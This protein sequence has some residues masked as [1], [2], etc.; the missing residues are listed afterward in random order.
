MLC[1]NPGKNRNQLFCEAGSASRPRPLMRHALERFTLDAAKFN[2]QIGICLLVIWI[3][4]VTCAVFSIRSQGFSAQQQRIW[5]W[6]VIGIPLFGL[7]IYLPF[8][9]RKDDLPQ[10]I[11]IAFHKKRQKKNPP[12]VAITD[13]RRPS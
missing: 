5:M 8:S 4:M 6:V 11:Q 1:R 3:V 2:W 12:K 10:F 13:G 9:V 7:L